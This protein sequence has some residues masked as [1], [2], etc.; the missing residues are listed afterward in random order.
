MPSQALKEHESGSW[1][2]QGQVARERQSFVLEPLPSGIVVQCHR[3]K[4][5]L[6]PVKELQNQASENVL[7]SQEYP[8]LNL[9]SP[10]KCPLAPSRSWVNACFLPPPF[11]TLEWGTC[12]GGR[13][14][15]KKPS[16]GEKAVR[17]M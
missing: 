1:R 14:T 8:S 11:P 6:N 4:G 10:V 15:E 13:I 7:L 5:S 9:A 12:L 17:E 3:G 16:S 2:S